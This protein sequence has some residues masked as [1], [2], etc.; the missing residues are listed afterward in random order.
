MRRTL[1]VLSVL[2]VLTLGCSRKSKL[3]EALKPTAL[4]AAIAES[5]GGKRIGSIGM[6]LDQPLVVQV[7]DATGG[8]VA[9]AAVYFTGPAGVT[10]KPAADSI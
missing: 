2:A 6:P 9:G 4:G 3:P 8:G 10:F 5:G 7:N 1:F